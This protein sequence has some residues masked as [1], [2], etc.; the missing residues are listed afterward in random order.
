M[1]QRS[2]ERQT[3]EVGPGLQHETI[4]SAL[5]VAG[6]YDRILVHPGIYDEQVTLS[7]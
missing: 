4:K 2:R 5:S 1:L 6:E 3:I 7:F